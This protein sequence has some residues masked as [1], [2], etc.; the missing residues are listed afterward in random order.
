MHRAWSAAKEKPHDQKSKIQKLQNR[1]T[2]KSEKPKEPKSK[3]TKAKAKSPRSNQD[4]EI[5]L[6]KKC[7]RGRFV[8]GNPFPLPAKLWI[9]RG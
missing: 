1:K 7:R 5:S 9:V 8:R 3:Y 6:I 4:W 2:A